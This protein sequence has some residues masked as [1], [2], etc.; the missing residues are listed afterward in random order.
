MMI[1]EILKLIA[2]GTPI[3]DGLENI[4]KAK[5]GALIVIS[6]TKEVLDL[7]DGGFRLDIDYTS[8]RLYELAKMDGA[9]VLSADFKKILY[10]NTQLIPD[11]SIIT[12]ETGTRHR[13]AERT[14]KQT[15]ALVISISQRRSIITIF[16]GNERYVLE[17][18]SKVI[19]KANQALQTVEKYK[20]VFDSKLSLLNE[21]EFNDI[22]TLENVIISIQ[23]AEMVRKMVEEVERAIFELGDEGRLLEIQLKELV[24]DLENEELLIV[25]DYM[26]PSKKKLPDKI[27]EEIEKLNHEDLMKSDKIAKML[28]YQDFENYDEVGVYTR[29]YRVLNKIPRMPSNIVDNLVK[30]FKSFQHILAADIPQLDEVE[31]IGEVRARTIK[32]SLKRM[33]EQFVFDNLIL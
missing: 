27:L 20:K 26:S 7:V 6:D 12:T 15:G 14:A 4:L 3:R 5:T 32:Q 29:G 2:P 13:T 1:T 21:Y 16:K 18:T 30:S 9:I 11:S 23:R 10:A 33:Q 25:K 17:D 19:S 22:V 28:G 31:G 24:G 8:S